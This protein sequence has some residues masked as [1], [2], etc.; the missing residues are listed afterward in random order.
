[1][2]AATTCD[3]CAKI[4]PAPPVGWIIMA[5]VEQPSYSPLSSILPQRTTPAIG[6]KL[7]AVTADLDALPPR[8]RVDACGARRRL[9]ALVV[10]GWP[11][12][13]LAER[14]GCSHVYLNQVICGLRRQVGART[15]RSVAALHREL[16]LSEPPQSTPRERARVT[17]AR[18]RAAANGWVSSL[19]WDE[20]G[21]HG[22]DNP[23]A[24]PHGLREVA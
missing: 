14:L 20:S 6:R 17:Q 10:T 9:Q 11:V 19:A 8:A 16:W 4:G 22:I 15:V 5:P 24:V 12:S 2:G 13:M 23:A 21:P 3:G 18:N 1:M 7:L